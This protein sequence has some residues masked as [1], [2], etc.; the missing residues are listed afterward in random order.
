MVWESQ[1][2]TTSALEER[3]KAKGNCRKENDGQVWAL[4]CIWVSQKHRCDV[5]V[6]IQL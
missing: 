6:V 2:G 5:P 3:E 4:T 1:T